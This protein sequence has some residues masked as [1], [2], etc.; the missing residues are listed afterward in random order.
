LWNGALQCWVDQNW[1]PVT[2]AQLDAIAEISREIGE[3]VDMNYGC[4]GSGAH[5]EDMETAYE[6]NFR[7]DSS[8][9]VKYRCCDIWGDPYYT[10]FEW[11]ELMMNQLNINRPIQYGIPGHSLNVDGWKMEQIGD[12][13]YWYHMNYGWGGGGFDP[14]DPEWQGYTS[15][16]AWFALDAHPGGST[17]EDELI[18]T[19]VPNCAIGDWMSGSYGVPSPINVRYFDQDTAGENATFAAGIWFQALEPGGVIRGTGTGGDAITFNGAPGDE[20]R[21]YFSADFDT[22]TRIRIVDGSIKLSNGGEM[23]IH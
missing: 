6:E 1:V 23:V 12:E 20:S 18:R 21:F 8:C 14:N 2:Q 22:Y 9:N 13:Y 19:I 7:Y 5:H 11:Y 16:N 15:S 17:S 4:D 3:A 10:A